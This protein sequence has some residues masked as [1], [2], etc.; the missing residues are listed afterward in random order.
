MSVASH[1]PSD[2]CDD[3][4]NTGD[5]DSTVPF[6]PSSDPDNEAVSL[7]LF[8]FNSPGVDEAMVVEDAEAN[9]NDTEDGDAVWGVFNTDDPTEL[10]RLLVS[11]LSRALLDPGRNLL[12][13]SSLR[14]RER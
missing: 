13:S 4:D 1:E 12:A 10:D 9:A 5:L 7:D 11:S 6:P 8:S 14:L 2:N 3:D